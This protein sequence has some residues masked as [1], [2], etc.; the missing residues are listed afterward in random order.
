MKCGKVSLQERSRA[1]I[2]T[3]IPNEKPRRYCEKRLINPEHEEDPRWLIGLQRY[4]CN[5]NEPIL[6][7]SHNS[8]RVQQE[9]LDLFLSVQN[10]QF[11]GEAQQSKRPRTSFKYKTLLNKQK[12]RMFVKELIEEVHNEPGRTSELTYYFDDYAKYL[13]RSGN[14]S[15]KSSLINVTNESKTNKA[16]QTQFR[17]S[18]TN[19]QLKKVKKTRKR[20]TVPRTK[21]ND[22]INDKNLEKA[23]ISFHKHGKTKILT[24]SRNESPSTL[25]V[26]RVD[27]VCYQSGSSMSLYE[28]NKPVKES[29]DHNNNYR[30]DLKHKHLANKYLLTSSVKTLDENTR[31]AKVTL[32]CKTFKLAER[33]RIASER[34]TKF[35]KENVNITIKH[36]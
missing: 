14:S 31:G 13:D 18:D 6:N 24:I 30:I 36:K 15:E 19:V 8:G 26:I 16:I 10:L 22:E 21:K 7:E 28:D 11:Q 29:N 4:Y 2:K 32:L 25:Q 9:N 34:K 3:A 35:L 23:Q 17:G 20:D 1:R 33:S 27:V 5:E 12:H